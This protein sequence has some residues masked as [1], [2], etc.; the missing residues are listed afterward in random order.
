MPTEYKHPTLVSNI[1]RE[2]F[3][4]IL[5]LPRRKHIETRAMSPYW[6]ARLDKIDTSAPFRIRMINGYT[7]PIPEATVEVVRVRK[8]SRT[9]EF[10]F[11][12][13][14]VFDVKHWDRRREVPTP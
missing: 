5:A 10:E 13:G 8:M 9:N 4:D 11:H 3:A 6:I 2:A 12:L 7:H 14:R 1:K